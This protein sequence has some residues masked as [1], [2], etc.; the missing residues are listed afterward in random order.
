MRDDTVIFRNG[1]KK[2]LCTVYTSSWLPG[3][4]DRVGREGLADMGFPSDWQ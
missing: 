4:V 1:M 2:A 3:C